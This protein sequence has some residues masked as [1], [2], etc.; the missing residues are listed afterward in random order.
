MYQWLDGGHQSMDC[1]VIF[2]RHPYLLSIRILLISRLVRTTTW[3]L[4][5][6]KLNHSYDPSHDIYVTI[7]S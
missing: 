3:A 4:L 6:E 5:V 2:V 1:A 7:V